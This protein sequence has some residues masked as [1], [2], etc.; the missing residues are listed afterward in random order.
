MK[1]V[2]KISFGEA[3]SFLKSITKQEEEA[4]L[5]EARRMRLNYLGG[6]PN[7]HIRPNPPKVAKP[8]QGLSLGNMPLTPEQ[9]YFTSP[10]QKAAFMRMIAEAAAREKSE[11]IDNPETDFAEQLMLQ[12]Y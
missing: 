10:Q 7:V 9:Q 4:E 12:G 3:W 6:G 11:D 5:P 8:E 1:N 2:R